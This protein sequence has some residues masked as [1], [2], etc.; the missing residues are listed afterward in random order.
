MTKK[1]YAREIVT[2]YLQDI[3][4][5]YC[6]SAVLHTCRCYRI[7]AYRLTHG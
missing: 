4:Q 7:Y 3:F 1:T 6:G 5:L 2:E